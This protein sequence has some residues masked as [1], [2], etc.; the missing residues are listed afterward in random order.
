MNYA[1]DFNLLIV[2]RWWG[3]DQLIENNHWSWRAAKVMWL[4]SLEWECGN[5]MIWWVWYNYDD[6]EDD[7]KCDH[8]LRGAKQVVRLGNLQQRWRPT[9]KAKFIGTLM[10]M[11]TMSNKLILDYYCKLLIRWNQPLLLLSSLPL[12]PTTAALPPPQP[13]TSALVVILDVLASPVS[14]LMIIVGHYK[15]YPF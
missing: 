5:M 13:S 2:K 9:K 15:I 12:W 3:S 1:Y 4:G 8:W 11:I 14:T 6:D 7:G 10:T